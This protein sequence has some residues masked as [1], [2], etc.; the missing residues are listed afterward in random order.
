MIVLGNQATR[1]RVSLLGP[2]VIPPHKGVSMGQKIS[3]PTGKLYF[4]THIPLCHA[5]VAGETFSRLKR[6]FPE[7]C[8]F[9]AS[10]PVPATGSCIDFIIPP[11]RSGAMSA[12]WNGG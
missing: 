1:F 5:N 11:D 12:L 10:S 7:I 4:L 9:G 3:F 8:Q 2:S 6:K